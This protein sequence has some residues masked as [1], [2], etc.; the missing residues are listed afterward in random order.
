MADW[1]GD[2]DTPQA[3][4]L[5]DRLTKNQS[6][7][8]WL[9]GKAQGRGVPSWDP[10]T[11]GRLGGYPGREPGMPR[12]PGNT[13]IPGSN[14][15]GG[16]YAPSGN[17]P[18]GG[19]GGAAAPPGGGGA[20]GMPPGGSLPPGAGGSGMGGIGSTIPRVLRGVG[21]IAR[22]LRGV[23]TG[24]LTVPAYAASNRSIYPSIEALAASRSH[25]RGGAQPTQPPNG[26]PMMP[27]PIPNAPAKPPPA[28]LIS[29][30][31]AGDIRPTPVAPTSQPLAWQSPA[32][33]SNSTIPWPAGAKPSV[34]ASPAPA[35][36]SPMPGVMV[37][38]GGKAPANVPARH[39]APQLPLPRPSPIAKRIPL[40]RPAQRMP[41]IR[42]QTAGK[43]AAVDSL[44][45]ALF[46]SPVVRDRQLEG[47]F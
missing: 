14:R 23:P 31:V 30:A 2:E 41:Q 13:N 29:P 6:F 36:N 39:Y 32:P 35:V 27:I 21:T 42:P 34:P 4:E 37:P 20:G 16:T 8:D 5:A 26:G 33:L 3:K 28:Q 11:A 7:I 19:V 22:A 38:P 18:A 17:M 43:E 1:L 24:A 47:R 45:K 44:M 40:P 46:G 12:A 15:F 9:R 25:L 10:A